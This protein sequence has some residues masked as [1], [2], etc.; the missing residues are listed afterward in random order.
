MVSQTNSN[1]RSL[2][3]CASRSPGPEP[4]IEVKDFSLDA[5]AKYST[6]PVVW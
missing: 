6:I 4:I 5:T 2:G 3:R 1:K